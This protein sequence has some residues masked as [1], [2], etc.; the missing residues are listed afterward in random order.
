MKRS[1]AIQLAAWFGLASAALGCA[2]IAGLTED[3][4][5][6][7]TG[8]GAG[9][10]GTA[11]AA[12]RVGSGGNVNA[13]GDAGAAGDFGSGGEAG[14]SSDNGGS[15][16]NGG[17]ASSTG[18]TS[19]KSGAGGGGTSGAGG[20]GAGGS[21]TSGAG[22]SGG[23][24]GSGLAGAAGGGTSGPTR[25]GFSVFHDSASGNDDASAHLANASFTKP[26]GTAAG[27]LILVFFGSDH[28]LSN[29]S[30]N[31]L[32]AAGWTL[33]DQHADYGTDGQGSYLIYKFAGNNEPDPIV[34][35]DI[36]P[37]G[38]G[39][40]VQGLLSVY[41]GVNPS[42]P[43]NAYEYSLLKE[44]MNGTKVVT[45]TPAITTTVPNCLLVAGLSPDTT[46][47]RP[48]ID[49]WPQGFDEDQVSVVNPPNP[50]PLGW[51]NIFSAER[52]LPAAGTVAASAFHWTMTNDN[53]GGNYFGS[54]AFVLAL[55]PKP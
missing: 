5:R 20:S 7:S 36:N 1:R 46:V 54:L 49:S 51:A 12:G 32:S 53:E 48:V 19:G 35:S 14:T 2:Q 28:S 37:A 40:G 25:V 34:F 13:G 31:T 27:D 21:G 42:S 15:G 22:G 29:L 16:A 52:H 18:G 23:A 50:Y 4:Q 43:V 45:A 17:G 11:G 33:L 38:S 26:N 30:G 55:S 39:N 6:A 24:A 10:G 3:Y 44:G 8:G 47:D 9:A 41:R